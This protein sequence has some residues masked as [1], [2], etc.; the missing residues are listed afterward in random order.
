MLANI[1]SNTPQTIKAKGKIYLYNQYIFLNELNKGV[2]IINNSNPAN[3]QRVAFIDIPGNVDIAVKGNTLY[4]DLYTDLLALDITN[5]LQSRLK[6]VIPKIFP[7]RSFGNGFMP[8]STRVIVDWIKKDTTVKVQ[9]EVMNPACANCSGFFL[10]DR[11]AASPASF[12]PGIAGSM[13]RFSIVNDFM[14]AVNLHSLNVLDIKEPEDPI[15]VSTASVGWNIETIYPFK[16]KL[17]IGSSSGLFIFDI[18]NPAAPVRQGQFNHARACDPV[19]ADDNYAYVTL[20]TG[21]F[22]TGTNNQLDIV[23]VQN[24]LAPALTKTYPMSNPH[25]LSKDGDLLFI[26]DGK[27]GLKVFNAA[28]VYD[29]KQ[30]EHLKGLEAYDAIA[31]NNNLIVVAEDGLYQY[32]YTSGTDLKLLSKISIDQ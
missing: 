19:V 13:S 16:N 5:P 24:V 30:I 3:P 25:G 17:F 1:K 14:Y 9:D 7:E 26:C 29:L 21:S 23:N 32:H 12:V 10:A 28:N 18:S 20:R 31:W 8:D 6:K 2:H 4:A 22:C 11:N 27:E 15:K